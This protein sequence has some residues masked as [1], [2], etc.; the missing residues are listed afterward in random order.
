MK[1]RPIKIDGI[2]NQDTI[3]PDNVLPSVSKTGSKTF[4]SLLKTSFKEINSSPVIFK[5]TLFN[6]DAPVSA[7]V[8]TSGPGF[9]SG[10]AIV[11]RNEGKGYVKND[12]QKGPSKMG[13][14]Q[15]TARDYGYYGKIKNITRAQTEAIYK[16]I[17]DKS[18]AA[19]LP[20]PLSA[21]H[22]DTYVNSPAAARKI[23]K[24][25][26]GDVD[27]YLDLRAQRYSRL[28]A[29]KPARFAKYLNGWMNRISGLRNIATA[30]AKATGTGN[31]IA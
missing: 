20:Y 19:S 17:W 2:G 18:G 29:V 26:G 16:K 31:K 5:K 25:S 12:A 7:T 24:Q 9:R 11:L 15:S 1:D 23:L 30:Y 3:S 6:M 4:D 14:L 28:A 27:T 8:K 21:V 22:F 13:I 10:L